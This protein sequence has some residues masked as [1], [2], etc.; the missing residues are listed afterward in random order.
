VT[1]RASRP[2]QV[3]IGVALGLLT[4]LTALVVAGWAPLMEADTAM[5]GAARSD[6]PQA[7]IDV[8]SVV[9]HLGD[10]LPLL[11]AAFALTVVLLIRKRYG[12]AAFVVLAAASTELAWLGLRAVVGRDR[13]VDNHVGLDTPAFPSGHSVHAVTAGLVAIVLLWPYVGR[14]AR[15]SIAG[16][17]AVAALAV[18][19]T[20]V[21]LLAH[22]P[23]DV[24]GGYL[25]AVGLVL[26][27]AYLLPIGSRATTASAASSANVPAATTPTGMSQ[28]GDPLATGYGATNGTTDH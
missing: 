3:T 25:L 1:H 10:G 27:L 17:A 8:A 12:T 11:A 14:V 6:L 5:S 4:G 19:A 18:G 7:W 23:S 20:R 22:W 21:V 2:V 26:A 13:P 15:W 24:L 16:V 9:T 28:K